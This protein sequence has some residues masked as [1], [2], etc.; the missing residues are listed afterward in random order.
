M[1]YKT[2]NQVLDCQLLWIHIVGIPLEKEF[3]LEVALDS[4]GMTRFV[5][6]TNSADNKMHLLLTMNNVLNK[7][8]KLPGGNHLL[9]CS[10]NFSLEV[11]YEGLKM[12][13]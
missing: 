9:L 8:L 3:G 1:L 2:L 12:P 10:T 6:K 7:K 5:I 11:M 4:S 13:V